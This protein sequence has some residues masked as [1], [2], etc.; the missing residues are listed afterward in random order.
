M[1]QLRFCVICF[2]GEFKCKLISNRKTCSTICSVKYIDIKREIYAKPYRDSHKK[3][4]EVYKK[5]NYIKNKKHILEKSKKY[6]K[7]N[8]EKMLLYAVKHFEKYG[9]ILDI[10]SKQYKTALYRWSKA[11]KKR[12]NYT[13]QDCGS[14]EN[15]HAHHVLSKRDFPEFSLL[16]MNGIT[17]CFDCHWKIHRQ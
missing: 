12:D 9:S 8:P 17:E 1:K 2:I 4:S 6:R 16:I 14:T 7:D 13:C 10:N 3:E 5:Q 11:I 15:L